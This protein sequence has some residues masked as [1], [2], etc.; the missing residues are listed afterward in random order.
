MTQAVRMPIA[1]GNMRPLNG[2]VFNKPGVQYTE[3]FYTYGINF[4]NLA[5]GSAAV[6]QSIVIQADSHFEWI[7]STWF[8]LVAGQVAP[9]QDQIIAPLFVQISDGGSGRQLQSAPIPLS[10]I[11][12]IGRDPFYLPVPRIF[13]SKSQI[14][15]NLLNED[16][17]AGYNNIQLNLHGRKIFE[18]GSGSFPL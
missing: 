3:D 8:A 5:F 10:S 13:L 15:F 9:F 1:R 7:M 2:H 14:T 6:Q 18:S 17:A 16:P 4:G 12:G 11:A